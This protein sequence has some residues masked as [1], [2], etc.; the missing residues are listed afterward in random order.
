[1]LTDEIK[2]SLKVLPSNPGVYHFLDSK[3]RIIYIGK[4]KNLKSRVQSYFTG[5]HEH[6]KT[7]ILVNSIFKIEYLIVETETDAL[8]LEN[9]L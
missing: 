6:F 8:L 3:G 9:N 7:K 4:A 1:M 5:K 2:N